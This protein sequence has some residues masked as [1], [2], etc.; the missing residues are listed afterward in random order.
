MANYHEPVL[1]KEVLDYLNISPGKKYV[2]ATVGGGGHGAAILKLG[3]KLL[4]I[5]TDPEAIKAAGRRLS[6][7]CPSPDFSGDNASWRLAQGN[8]ADL[9]KIVTKQ[10]WEKTDGILFDLGV[11][12]HQLES[13]ERGFSFRDDTPLDMRMSPELKVTAADLVNGLHKG[14]LSELFTKYGQ[15]KLA[16]R[17]AQAVIRARRLK[18][19]KTG[20]QLAQIIDRAYPD[21]KKKERIHP[22]T[23][24]FLALR[25]AVND[26]INNL[27][28]A[29]PQ[30]LALLGK[31][32][33]LVVISFHSGE[34]RLVKKFFLIQRKALTVLTLKPITPSVA[35]V[36][37]NPR[38][39]SAKLRAAEKNESEKE[40]KEK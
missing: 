15:E 3:G 27:K 11:S 1:L 26:E 13:P 34:D 4:G 22:A 5:D 14:E 8:F 10:G 24:V 30:A 18:P 20:R 17:F 23:R 7:A 39:R 35:E 6:Q 29:L 33:R 12:S 21:R 19:I 37:Q 9:K 31:K 38:S 32:G 16:R 36:K 25:I 40:K 28:K 2:D